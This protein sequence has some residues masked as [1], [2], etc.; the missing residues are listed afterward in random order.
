MDKYAE[1]R[2]F[3]PGLFGKSDDEAPQKPPLLMRIAEKLPEAPRNHAI[4]MAGEFAG[5]FM[6]LFFAFAAAQI[7]NTSKNVSGLGGS[8]NEKETVADVGSL[9]Y[10]AVA[11]G[12]SLAVNAWVFYRISGGLFNP[13][14]SLA[15][16]LV[17][18]IEPMRALVTFIAQILGGISCAAVVSCLFPGPLKVTTR[19]GGGTSIVQGLF[20]EMFLTTGLVFTILMLAVEK[21]KATYIAPLGIGLALF[22]TQLAGVYFTGAS[23]NPARSLGPDVATLSFPGYSWIYWLGP[24]L[25]SLVAVTFY[26]TLKG[27]QYETA[28]PGQDFDDLEHS[29]FDPTVDIT[30]PTVDRLGE[31][32]RG[33][34]RGFSTMSTEDGSSA[35]E[36]RTKTEGGTTEHRSTNGN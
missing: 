33:R 11:F 26:E 31:L 22:I 35:G 23:L 7:A 34:S 8:A 16:F 3:L 29:A 6:F 13:A 17:G 24:A 12:F 10:I 28:N 25:G 2:G 32:S 20:I 14:V 1:T 27:L 18:A 5:T 30:R 9:M 19:L 21:S 36:G 15:L 4:A